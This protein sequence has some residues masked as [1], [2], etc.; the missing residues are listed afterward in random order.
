[1]PS[2]HLRVIKTVPL[3]PHWLCVVVDGT[4]A[5][6]MI[7]YGFLKQPALAQKLAYAV[8]GRVANTHI[9]FDKFN[10]GSQFRRVNDLLTNQQPDVLG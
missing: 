6:L 4:F 7:Y 2:Q 5:Y 9:A 1:M 8:M 10:G 3:R